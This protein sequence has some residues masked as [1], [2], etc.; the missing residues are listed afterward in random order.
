[1]KNA[2]QSARFASNEL[3]D[4]F[5]QQRQA[6]YEEI[7]KKAMTQNVNIKMLTGV[8]DEKE[9]AIY[10]QA[11]VLYN[12]GRYKEAS[13]VFRVL[14]LLNSLE[15]KYT[16]GL[17]ACFHLMKEYEAASNM[18]TI[19][20]IL[21]SQNP[22][23]YFHMSD[24][25]LQLGDKFAAAVA[26]DLAIKRADGKPEFSVLKERSIITLDGLEERTLKEIKL[27]RRLILWATHNFP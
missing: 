24:C 7:S 5:K 19:C 20:S 18:Y 6:A 27:L 14:I 21:D 26:L 9:E 17:A 3:G 1:M 13:E 22:I 12:T 4:N 15:P 10:G 23:P 2:K 11:Y 8:S 16:L 25:A